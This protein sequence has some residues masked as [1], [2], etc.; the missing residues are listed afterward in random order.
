MRG[1]VDGRGLVVGL[2]NGAEM[3]RRVERI[4]DAVTREA[5]SLSQRHLD[6]GVA[7]QIDLIVRRTIA[8]VDGII[9]R[10][11][12]D[13]AIL[14]AH[15][16]LARVQGRAG[17]IALI[18]IEQARKRNHVGAADRLAILLDHGRAIVVLHR[19]QCCAGVDVAR[20]DAVTLTLVQHEILDDIAILIERIVGTR[21][22]IQR[23]V[24]AVALRGHLQH[25]AGL[26]VLAY[27]LLF[28]A[29]IINVVGTLE[30]IVQLDGLPV[31]LGTQIAHEILRGLRLLAL[32]RIGVARHGRRA[33]V[34]LRD[35]LRF[36]QGYILDG[37]RLDRALPRYRIGIKDIV[38]AAGGQARIFDQLGRNLAI[39]ITGHVGISCLA[40]RRIVVAVLVQR[41]QNRLGENT[42][43]AVALHQAIEA[44]LGKGQLIRISIGDTRRRRR[45]ISLVNICIRRQLHILQ[46]HRINGTGCPRQMLR[47]T[48]LPRLDIRAI[49]G[50]VLRMCTSERHIEVDVL[51]CRF[52]IGDT[53]ILRFAAIAIRHLICT[54][55]RPLQAG[56]RVHD[57][58][59]RRIAHDIA[60]RR[61]L[62]TDD[63][64]IAVIRLVDARRIFQHT[65]REREAVD[66]ALALDI[67]IGFRLQGF[68]IQGIVPQYRFGRTVQDTRLRKVAH[69]L[70]GVRIAGIRGI[71]R[72][73]P[74]CVL[75]FSRLC[76]KTDIGIIGRNNACTII[77][78]LARFLILCRRDHRTIGNGVGGGAIISFPGGFC[79]ITVFVF[80]DKSV[81]VQHTLFDAARRIVVS[82]II[83]EDIAIGINQL[84]IGRICLCIERDVAVAYRLGTTGGSIGIVSSI[85]RGLAVL[86]HIARLHIRGIEADSIVWH[87][88]GRI[89]LDNI[90]RRIERIRR[91]IIIFINRRVT[92]AL[93]IERTLLDIRL[94]L[95]F[96]D[97][98]H[99][100]LIVSRIRAANLHR[101]AFIGNGNAVGLALV[102]RGVVTHRP[103]FRPQRRRQAID[104]RI[105]PLD[106][107]DSRTDVLDRERRRTIIDALELDRRAREVEVLL[108][109]CQVIANE[110]VA[111]LSTVEQG[112]RSRILHR[113]CTDTLDQGIASI[114]I[115]RLIIAIHGLEIVAIVDERQILAHGMTGERLLLRLRQAHVVRIGRGQAIGVQFPRIRLLAVMEE[116][117]LV[118]DQ[119]RAPGREEAAQQ[120]Q[121]LPVIDTPYRILA[122]IFADCSLTTLVAINRPATIIRRILRHVIC[123]LQI[124]R[125]SNNTG[126]ICFIIVSKSINYFILAIAILIV[127]YTEEF[128]IGV[129]LRF[130]IVHI[131][132]FTTIGDITSDTRTTK[133]RNILGIRFFYCATIQDT[134][135]TTI[136]ARATRMS[137]ST[138]TIK[139]TIFNIGLAN[140][141]ASTQ[142]TSY[143]TNQIRCRCL[144]NDAQM[145]DSTGHITKQT[146]LPITICR[147]VTNLKEIAI[148]GTRKDPFAVATNRGKGA[149]LQVNISA[150]LIVTGQKSGILLIGTQILQ[151]FSRRN[152]SKSRWRQSHPAG[153]GHRI[154]WRRGCR[155]IIMSQLDGRVRLQGHIR[156][157]RR[158]LR[159]IEELNRT[160]L[161]RHL[162]RC[163]LPHV[164]N[165]GRG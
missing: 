86:I 93:Q 100:Q 26:C 77:A 141:S 145:L 129:F 134:D 55:N 117:I 24:A 102:L 144:V 11:L 40:V 52:A 50:I 23:I 109:D 62:A 8:E 61:V 154:A 107:A 81:D 36:R 160:A 103:L 45:V 27:I 9:H 126:K 92:A 66:P 25:E 16:I 98:L 42:A 33:V 165:I 57:M 135:N 64:I 30:G 74:V 147:K 76:G 132:N 28:V 48:L 34:D 101:T 54:C 105:I 84:I 137:V 15:D 73:F 149:I 94:D 125:I 78:I 53:D 158:H 118:I 122:T 21:T 49:Q 60:E 138:R 35:G 75:E 115:Q 3:H 91:T 87:Q 7:V 88:T 89:D 31:H 143:T 69:L 32:R 59:I 79:R 114:G 162:I 20:R 43:L 104:L 123:R 6:V 4:D 106:D 157:L 152:R 41:I 153:I 17:I 140:H 13:A 112:V 63:F 51:R 108:I 155:G 70:C 44:H 83:L 139:C 90:R 161:N 95:D 56:I 164:D 67:I 99:R 159:R 128:A 82:G 22:A 12:A 58:V 136:S 146:A 111:I 131:V 2:G 120:R 65:N 47:L 96:I 85:G 19:L 5:A 14:I 10:L 113:I 142:A 151:L 18:G 130:R 38:I 72:C 148:K 150:E 29:A 80:H 68:A 127:I 133:S 119:L 124:N 97:A 1:I 110:V 163:D 71:H 121:A 116:I 39:L 46:V 37:K 156:R